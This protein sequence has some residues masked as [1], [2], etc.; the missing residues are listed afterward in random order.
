[1]PR[2]KLVLEYDGTEFVGWQ[3]QPNGRS[4][5]ATVEEALHKL[6]GHKVSVVAAGRTDSGVHAAGQVIAFNT[7]RA[8]P[9]KAYLQGLNGI[10]P[11]DIGVQSVEEVSSEFDPRRWALGKHYRYQ[12]LNSAARSPLLRRTHWQIFQPL[13]VEKMQQAGNVLLG[14]HDFSA[15]RAS[16]CQAAHPVREIRRLEFSRPAPREIRLDIEGTAFLKHMVRN[17]V[18]TL[19]EVGRGNQDIEWV[20]RVLKSKDREQAGRTAPGQGLT[21]MQVFYGPGPREESTEKPARNRSP[22]A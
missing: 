17:I 10:L 18:G 22:R 4:V 6:L 16:N 2:L 21:M 5:Q 19:V 7:D 13:D 3:M 11:E 8:F 9:D 15:F 20:A 14:R 12:I 1:M